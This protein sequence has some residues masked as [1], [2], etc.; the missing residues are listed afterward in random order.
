MAR[1]PSNE[2][3]LL[4]GASASAG[5]FVDAFK[6]L[7]VLHG[8]L[9]EWQQRQDGEDDLQYLHRLTRS[10]SNLG[11]A[12]GPG[13]LG[14][15]HVRN[16]DAEVTRTWVLEHVPAEWTSDDVVT[17]VKAS[18]SNVYM[19]SRRRSGRKLRDFF[20][21]SAKADLDLQPFVVQQE[22]GNVT[23]WAKHHMSKPFSAKDT[24]SLP[25]NRSMDLRVKHAG[26]WG[27]HQG[28]PNLSW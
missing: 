20:R 9:I 26:W 7:P 21:A 14:L 13:Q 19:L 27:G 6:T 5:W 2:V 3:D 11:I 15:R 25:A 8:R 23:F 18:F 24:K 17:L 16:P 28:G 10:H 1:V 4:L 22:G 12:A